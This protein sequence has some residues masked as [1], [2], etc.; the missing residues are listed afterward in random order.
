MGDDDIQWRVE[1]LLR[2]FDSGE[3][4]EAWNRLCVGLGEKC[5]LDKC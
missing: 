3:V 5:L 1:W 2:G 4:L